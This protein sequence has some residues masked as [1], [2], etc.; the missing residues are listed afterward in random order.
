M[1]QS[2]DQRVVRVRGMTGTGNQPA[3]VA[4]DRVNGTEVLPEVLD[5]TGK[6]R[7]W[8][9]GYDGVSPRDLV[10]TII[11]TVVPGA[12]PTDDD[13][14]AFISDNESLTKDGPFTLDGMSI[15]E[16]WAERS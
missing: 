16:W 1:A 3:T 2:D 11:R 15:E 12:T 14:R 9:W 7:Q 8:V 4:V 6:P 13:A 10:K 5:G